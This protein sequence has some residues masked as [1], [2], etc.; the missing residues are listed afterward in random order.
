MNRDE[1]ANLHHMEVDAFDASAQHMT[2]VNAENTSVHQRQYIAIQQTANVVY[3]PDPEQIEKLTQAHVAAALSEQRQQLQGEA[4]QM[5]FSAKDAITQAEREKQQTQVQ[6]EVGVARIHQEASEAIQKRDQ[7]SAELMGQLEAKGQIEQLNTIVYGSQSACA[8]VNVPPGLQQVPEPPR[9]PSGFP[10]RLWNDMTPGPASGGH[11]GADA[12]PQQVQRGDGHAASRRDKTSGSKKGFVKKQPTIP[13]DD[14]Q[15]SPSE[16]SSV[17]VEDEVAWGSSSDSSAAGHQ[18]WRDYDEFESSAYKHKNLK[19]IKVTRLPND[20][21]S[22]SFEGGS[23]SKFRKKLHSEKIFAQFN[24]H[25]AAEL[26]QPDVLATN[27]ELSH[28]LNSYVES[29][30]LKGEGPRAAPMLNLIYC[31]FS[32]GASQGVALNQMH[33]LNLKLEDTNAANVQAFIRRAHYIRNR[34][35]PEDRPNGKTLFHWLWHE[36]KR[37]PCLSRVTNKVR[38]SSPSSKR[39]GF[40]WLWN[41][42]QDELKERREDQNYDNLTKGLKEG[43]SPSLG[44]PA[45]QAKSDDAPALSSTN[46]SQAKGGK[47]KPKGSQGQGGTESTKVETPALP[48]ETKPPGKKFICATHAAGLCN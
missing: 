18:P 2:Q 44:L 36:V 13:E 1:S 11:N 6:A 25:L 24:K 12:A 46:A 47:S 14:P 42:I 16:D 19:M 29:C 9:I 10:A 8:G 5:A 7:Q 43:P 3:T 32:I 21:T 45:K 31:R 41:A 17:E 22:C 37:V 33:L 35:R 38:D 23:G 15:T 39:R 20:A 26:I 28:E 40:E 34:L 4:M 27:V 48:A 30:A